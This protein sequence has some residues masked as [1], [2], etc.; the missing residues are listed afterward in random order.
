VINKFKFA[1]L[2]FLAIS[3]C[4]F[5]D[6]KETE[7]KQKVHR[8]TNSDLKNTSIDAGQPTVRTDDTTVN[9]KKIIFSTFDLKIKD[10]AVVYGLNGID[11]GDSTREKLDF[12]KNKN[13]TITE[14]TDTIGLSI[15]DKLDNKLI[16]IIPHEKND[17]FKVSYCYQYTIEYEKRGAIYVTDTTAYKPLKDS[18]N[19]FFRIPL[20]EHISPLN[21]IKARIKV[22]DSVVK[23]V[24]GDYG[25]SKYTAYKVKGKLVVI[26]AMDICFKIER[27]QNNSLKETKVI[28]FYDFDPD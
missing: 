14:K 25:E 6:S 9:L 20:F 4:K 11:V 26:S 21:E 28:C 22:T 23:T 19:F 13:L 18:S 24:T 5:S 2:I 1:I 10:F 27:F 15:E 16:E 12:D 17:R 3:A 8:A 7:H